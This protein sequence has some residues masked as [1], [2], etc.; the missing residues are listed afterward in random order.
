MV[1]VKLALLSFALVANEGSSAVL[2]LSSVDSDASSSRRDGRASQERC[3]QD[4][5]GV[6]RQANNE[7]HITGPAGGVWRNLCP[8]NSIGRRQRT[9]SRFRESVL[10]SLTDAFFRTVYRAKH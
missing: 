5:A 10:N 1:A 8:A 7:R 2:C 9:P 6:D 3:F 4:G